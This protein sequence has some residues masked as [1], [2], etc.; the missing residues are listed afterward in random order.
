[1][2]SAIF[3]KAGVALLA[4]P[5]FFFGDTMDGQLVYSSLLYLHILLFVAWLGADIGVFALGQNFRK[6]EAYSL[7]TRLVLLKLLALVDMAPRTAWALMVPVS[8]TLAVLGGWTVLPGWLIGVSWVA[9]LG[10]L[11]LTWAAFLAGQTPRARALRGFEFYLTIALGA[12]YFALG[13]AGASGALAM[14]GWLALK[15]ALFGAIF[16]FATLTDLASRA[17]GPR[18]LALIEQGSSPETEAPLL[19]AMNRVRIWVLGLYVLLI[20][21]GAVGTFKPGG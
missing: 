12:G 4:R 1:M 5:A 6:R 11:G 20:A 8:L 3:S 13:A 17:V 18:L 10:W 2:A 19:K 15:A 14:P 9:G 16:A 21:V 7:E